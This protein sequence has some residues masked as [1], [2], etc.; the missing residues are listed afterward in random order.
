MIPFLLGI[1]LGLPLG[2]SVALWLLLAWAVG[3]GF[4]EREGAG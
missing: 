2:A 1:C 3:E 4:A